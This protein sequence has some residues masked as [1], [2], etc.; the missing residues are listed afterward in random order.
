M[1][2]VSSRSVFL[3]GRQHPKLVMKSE[4]VNK[5]DIPKQAGMAARALDDLPDGLNVDT[6]GRGVNGF[7]SVG[8]GPGAWSSGLKHSV[9]IM[10]LVG[11]IGAMVEFSVVSVVVLSG[12][13]DGLPTMVVVIGLMRDAGTI[14][15]DSVI[16]KE[17]DC[18]PVSVNRIVSVTV[19]TMYGF[20]RLSGLLDAEE[21]E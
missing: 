13:T 9:G 3:S 6:A 19:M 7:S 14:M 1:D 16:S 21:A 20:D 4:R 12:T 8:Q 17:L 2:F 10:E 15:V 18:S 5:T 11:A